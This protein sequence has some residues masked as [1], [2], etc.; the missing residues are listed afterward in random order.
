MDD[1]L[2]KIVV[3]LIA[4]VA[5]IVGAGISAL[6][7]LISSH[8]TRERELRKHIV[9]LAAQLAIKEW[10]AEND[11]DKRRYLHQIEEIKLRQARLGQPVN[12][13]P[14]FMAL[15]D[16]KSYVDKNM[17]LASA[18]LTPKPKSRWQSIKDWLGICH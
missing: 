2:N 16:L 14:T 1:I 8:W 12:E 15:P 10:E 7:V 3:A 17:K 4:A 11:S 6:A 13:L 5:L 18:M 9:D